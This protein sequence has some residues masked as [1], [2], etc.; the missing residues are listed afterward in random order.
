MV[1]L[2]ALGMQNVLAKDI[3]LRLYHR[4]ELT[5][6]EARVVLKVPLAENRLVAAALLT[7]SL[8]DGDRLHRLFGTVKV[9]WAAD[10]VE[11]SARARPRRIDF[12]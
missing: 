12:K 2:E 9:E 4:P 6:A 10:G 8:K 1:L 7:Q 5:T 3:V 11:R